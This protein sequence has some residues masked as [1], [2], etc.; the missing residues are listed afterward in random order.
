MLTLAVYAATA[1]FPSEERFGL[2][3]QLRRS[4]ASIPANI[5]EGCGRNGDAELARSMDVSM[6]SAKRAGVSP[7]AGL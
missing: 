6:G 5:A 3:S 7:T 4:A 2:I 1:G